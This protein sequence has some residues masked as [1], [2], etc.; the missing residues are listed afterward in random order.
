[1]YVSI[2]WHRTFHTY[3]F[4]ISSFAFSTLR[5][6]GDVPTHPQS[7]ANIALDID[8]TKEKLQNPVKNTEYSN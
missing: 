7:F 8:A 4:D 1:M 5:Q 2:P 6:G 3:S